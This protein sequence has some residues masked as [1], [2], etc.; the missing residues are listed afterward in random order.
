VATFTDDEY[1]YL[2]GQRL[3][4]LATIGPNGPQNHPVWYRVNEGSETIDIGGID[5][6]GSQKY[7][8]VRADPRVS[9]V[10]DEPDRPGEHDGHGIEV[11]GHVEIVRLATPLF[12]GFSDDALRIHPRRIVAWNIDGPGYNIRD[13]TAGR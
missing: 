4:R 7:R 11:R 6:A 1:A 5:L 2:A 9:L 12:T 10:V 3:G 8:N 13:A